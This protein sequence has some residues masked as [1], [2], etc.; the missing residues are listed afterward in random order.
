MVSNWEHNRVSDP[1]RIV[2][3]KEFIHDN[4]FIPNVIYLFTTDSKQY[5]CYDGAHRLL[6]AA[7]LYRDTQTIYPV[8]VSIYRVKAAEVST[9]IR[10]EF[11]NLNKRVAVP[12]HLLSEAHDGRLNK[13]IDAIV[14]NMKQTFGP[15]GVNSI[16]STS[17]DCKIPHVNADRLKEA[18][19]SG[20]SDVLSSH[21]QE[22]HDVSQMTDLLQHCVASINTELNQKYPN[23]NAKPQRIGCLLFA[24]GRDASDS[25][26]I[27]KNM[28]MTR[29]A[30]NMTT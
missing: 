4:H 19:F 29:V 28:L 30:A 7:E 24:C 9:L 12:S 10:K 22:F 18:M 3:L 26:S 25:L 27:F 23:A 5:F 20:I 15:P 2:E 21:N 6:A 8:C 1:D 17:D 16:F 11:R 14:A 13:V